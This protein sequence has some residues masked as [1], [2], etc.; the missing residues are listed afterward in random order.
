MVVTMVG[1]QEARERAGANPARLL[2]LMT[3]SFAIGQ[4]AGPI[5]SGLIDL[6]PLG[7]GAALGLALQLAAAAL[8]L[9]AAYLWRHADRGRSARQAR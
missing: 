9:S 4:L 7:H 5:A 8:A 2:G 3:A 6:L 1:M